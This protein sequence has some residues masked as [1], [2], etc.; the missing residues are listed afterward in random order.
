M[1][2]NLDESLEEVRRHTQLG[3]AKRDACF[4]RQIKAAMTAPGGSPSQAMGTAATNW[5]NTKSW[6]DFLGNDKIGI[7]QLRESR[8]QL[9]GARL[10]PRTDGVVPPRR[11]RD[12]L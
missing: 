9:I 5:A 2:M 3:H 1:I 8:Q 7:E 4:V 12:Q 10:S 11:L 6:Y